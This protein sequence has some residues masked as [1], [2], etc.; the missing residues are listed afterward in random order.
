MLYLSALERAVQNVSSEYS[1]TT[2]HACRG[3]NLNLQ[4]VIACRQNPHKQH[5]SQDFTVWTFN[6]QTED[7][8]SGSY[9]LSLDSALSEFCKRVKLHDIG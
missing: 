3:A 7:L 1:I 2:A 9:D 5:K 6:P 8:F 4:I